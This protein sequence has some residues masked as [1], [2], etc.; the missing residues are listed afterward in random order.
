MENTPTL[1]EDLSG[2]LI[3]GMSA[4]YKSAVTKGMQYYERRRQEGFN[5]FHRQLLS[6]TAT[7]EKVEYE[8]MFKITEDQYYALLSASIND[9]EKQKSHIYA[10]VYRSILNENIS[11]EK[12]S[13]IIRLAKDI[14]YSALV[15][16]PTIYI[17]KNYHTKYKSLSKYLNELYEKNIYELKFLDRSD[18]IKLPSGELQF[19]DSVVKIKENFFNE[20]INVFFTKEDLQPDKY[21]IDLWKDKHAL[22][23]TNDPFGEG[24]DIDV[25]KKI[26]NDISI[27]NE[28]QKYVHSLKENF[29][30]IIFN[31]DNVDSIN[32]MLED[33]AKLG[34]NN[35]IIKISFKYQAGKTDA[36]NLKDD[37]DINKFKEQF[38]D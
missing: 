27:P 26:L 21:H 31:I 1:F 19:S 33:A 37:N 17:Y 2:L 5:E 15:L 24:Y 23:V 6:G 29:A 13:K 28:A 7:K 36:L 12:Y 3:D 38:S 25:I 18:I 22:I 4:N 8:Q 34:R 11:K 20:I 35:K 32:G 30:Y 16:L 10:N 9:E 14:P